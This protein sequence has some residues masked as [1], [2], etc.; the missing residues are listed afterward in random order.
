[1]HVHPS[2]ML[3]HNILGHPDASRLAQIIAAVGLA[4]NMA[5][6]RAMATEGIQRGHMSLHARNVAV[7][8]LGGPDAVSALNSGPSKGEGA[9][10]LEMIAT[11]LAES[12]DGVSLTNA[13]DFAEK[14]GWETE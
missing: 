9:R 14:Q 11:H 2:Y 7:Q 1:M 12:G 6:I 5:A 4:Q 3:S 8:A 10:R 13:K